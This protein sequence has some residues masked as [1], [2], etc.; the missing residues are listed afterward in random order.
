MHWVCEFVRLLTSLAS[1][2][3]PYVSLVLYLPSFNFPLLIV[4]E[5]AYAAIAALCPHYPLLFSS[6]SSYRVYGLQSLSGST[7]RQM[8]MPL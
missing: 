7:I 1:L 3:T 5:C 8:D 6:P 4:Q 2:D